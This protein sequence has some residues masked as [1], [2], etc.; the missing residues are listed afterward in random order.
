M[1]KK[2]LYAAQMTAFDKD[3]NINLDGIRAL[4]RYNIDVNKIDGLYVCGSTGEAF[5]LNT[6]EKKQSWRPSMMKQTVRL[7]WL[8]KLAH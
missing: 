2:L 8:P 7:T 3:G 4:V 5:M 1:S 6:D